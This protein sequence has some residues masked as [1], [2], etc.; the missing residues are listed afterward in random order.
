MVNW[1]D[2]VMVS[3]PE[4]RLN[5]IA[6]P[7]SQLAIIYLKVSVPPSSALLVTTVE[8]VVILLTLLY[9]SVSDPLLFPLTR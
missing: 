8:R 7:V 2:N 3:L 6:S 5:V 1:E 9:S 4:V